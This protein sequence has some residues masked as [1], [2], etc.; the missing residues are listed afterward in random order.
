MKSAFK[1]KK[2]FY[3]YIKEQKNLK[4]KC[5]VVCIIELHTIS[6][7]HCHCDVHVRNSH[8]AGPAM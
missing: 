8:I 7:E 1:T 6:F 5:N 2:L 4:I 3:G